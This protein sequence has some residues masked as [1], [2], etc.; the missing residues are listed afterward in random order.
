MVIRIF[1][2]IPILGE[3]NSGEIMGELRFLPEDFEKDNF[4]SILNIKIKNL[5]MSIESQI[6]ELM[7]ESSD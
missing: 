6:L 5:C 7:P 2:D 1:S 3:K 4:R